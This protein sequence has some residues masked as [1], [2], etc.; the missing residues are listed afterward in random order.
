MTASTPQSLE[1]IDD[2]WLDELLDQAPAAPRSVARSAPPRVDPAFA[3]SIRNQL[4]RGRR[5]RAELERQ[6]ADLHRDIAQL[7]DELGV[8]RWFDELGARLDR[9]EAAPRSG[10]RAV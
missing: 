2:A 1:P 5:E 3:A 7:R 6:V 8:A 9:I 4:R 10:L